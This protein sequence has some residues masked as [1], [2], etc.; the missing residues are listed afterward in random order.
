MNP[1]QNPADNRALRPA[2][3]TLPS[4]SKLGPERGTMVRADRVI[5]HIS[6]DDV[7]RAAAAAAR[8]A[9]EG[10]T[11]GRGNAERDEL[12]ILTAFDP[13]LRISEVLGIR[14]CDLF[15]DEGRPRLRILGKG[16]KRAVVSISRSLFDR[17]L[18]YAYK[19]RL[20]SE[21]RF[22]PVTR[23]RAHQ[24]LGRAYEAAGIS[25]PEGVGTCHVL[26]HSGAIERLRETGN[27]R[28][29]QE[30]LRHAGPAQTLRYLKT[31]SAEDALRVQDQVDF[32]W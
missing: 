24:I 31:L 14:P 29:I 5:P 13:A 3:L 32:R 27:P 4:K 20:G 6:R 23:A 10:G 7:A 22:F 12:L 21:D 19:K 8:V 28:A 30:Q 25:K 15:E 18:G 1:T 9:R 17:M 11:R 26:R 16:K 2:K